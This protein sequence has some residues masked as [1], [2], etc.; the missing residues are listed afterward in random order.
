MGWTKEDTQELQ[1]FKYI[2][3][4][5]DVRFKQIIKEKLLNNRYII[6]VLNNEE[7]DEDEPDS[8]FNKAILPYF[9]LEDTL[10]KV[11]NALCYEISFRTVRYDKSSIWKECQIIFNAVCDLG[12]IIEK[13]TGIARH[14]LMAA[15]LLWQFNWT[16][17]F[18]MQI[19]CV[20]DEP[21][22]LGANLAC[23][24]LVFKGESPNSISQT[25][26]SSTRVINSDVVR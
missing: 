23:R 14:D 10:V 19:Q 7:L 5:D 12:D 8:Y 13:D 17:I 4:C 25:K 18:G 11:K 3:D 26:D 1:S 9:A 6:H 21:S 16:N 20:S 2:T 22:M 24:T 15:L